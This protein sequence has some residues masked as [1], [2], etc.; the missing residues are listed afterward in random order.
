MYISAPPSL[1]LSSLPSSS[2]APQ[3]LASSA[4]VATSQN[5]EKNKATTKPSEAVE[6]FQATA[7]E[8]PAVASVIDST[9]GSLDK[10]LTSKPSTIS[11]QQLMDRACIIVFEVDPNVD[12]AYFRGS[13]HLESS[14][15]DHCAYLC[16]RDACTA[17]IFSPPSTPGKRGVC[18]R[19]F[20]G[21]E[22]CNG[23]LRRDYYYKTTRPI[24]LQCFRCLPEKPQTKPPLE[25]TTPKS[26]VL[27]PQTP[28][29]S[30]KQ[31]S[32]PEA[33][34]SPE[35][36][37]EAPK[38]EA[39]EASQA[40]A[41]GTP[42]SKAEKIETGVPGTIAPEPA[43][44]SGEA[45]AADEVSKEKS[46]R[47][48]STGASESS[49]SSAGSSEEGIKSTTV[50]EKPEAKASEQPTPSA[51]ETAKPEAGTPKSAEEGTVTPTIVAGKTKEEEAGAAASALPGYEPVEE[52]KGAAP[53]GTTP[54]PSGI[55]SIGT[56][57]TGKVAEATSKATVG[58]EAATT[59]PEVTA[60]EAGPSKE[61]GTTPQEAAQPA[62]SEE[63]P[64]GT[65]EVPTS[66][67]AAAPSTGGEST[68]EAGTKESSEATASAGKEETQPVQTTPSEVKPE[69]GSSAVVTAPVG[70]SEA[71]V[72]TRE[73]PTP[74]A[75]PE[76]ETAA[77]DLYGAAS[78]AMMPGSTPPPTKSAPEP[79][80]PKAE[81]AASKGEV[82]KPVG[83]K[84]S[85]EIPPLSEPKLADETEKLAVSTAESKEATQAASGS[86]T[87]P[88]HDTGA[89][90]EAAKPN[91]E[92]ASGTVA[93]PAAET[94]VVPPAATDKS[95]SIPVEKERREELS[96]PPSKLPA[97][98]PYKY[99]QG[100]LMS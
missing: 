75:A 49:K 10:D 91:A 46:I 61:E 84:A 70:P 97:A 85:S 66:A 76:G 53:P 23:T 31:E 40:P 48:E 81:E 35:S 25:V 100:I 1:A 36:A 22:K 29:A 11:K 64:G 39:T 55:S 18:E 96:K 16:Y 24:Y 73:Q 57:E 80:T 20:D 82:Q 28:P 59:V 30:A 44:G 38:T 34:V 77:A 33:A 21:V 60:S 37:S 95:Q 26:E 43:S 98:S 2:S 93:A 41:P 17:A 9:S 14:G 65:K 32:V 8:Q 79:E 7:N 68:A 47:E 6:G 56:S 92:V 13:D 4:R 27:V 12:L 69:A 87:A 67:T 51:A 58:Q 72:G 5:S 90:L 74:P 83:G 54:P 78:T 89:T 50:S 52:G 3:V 88:A 45:S 94:V 42:E 19:R 62:K 71:A 63:A 86:P 15:A 99:L